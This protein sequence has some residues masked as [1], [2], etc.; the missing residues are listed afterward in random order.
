MK[1]LLTGASS[2]I[3][4]FLL[5][6]LVEEGH[7]CICVSRKM[8]DNHAGIQWVIADMIE[9]MPHIWQNNDAL[10]WVHLGFLP[11]VISHLKAASKAGVR[12]FIAFSSTSVFTK[13][14]SES[15]KE[16]LTIQCLLEAEK[17][18]QSQCRTYGVAWTLFR[19]TMI[20]GCGMDQNIAFI[21]NTIA[22]F[23]IFPIAGKAK[24]LRQPV[25]A[26]DLAKAC[27][28][29]LGAESAHNKA[30]NLSGGEVLSYHAM[31]EYVFRSMNRT[32]KIIGVPLPIYKLAIIILKQV[33]SRH[34][35]IQTAMVDRMNM[36]MVFDH[37]DAT[38]DFD[39][40][41]RTFQP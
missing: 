16:R 9:D 7:Q 6:M 19:P 28:Q 14:K 30:Y 41:P 34:K 20:Y 24:G 17:E 32:P 27:L 1:I 21:Q 8:Y 23:G 29:V 12:H 35:F 3:G 40:N 13:E 36:D 5:P 11:L 22:R 18:V 33:S 38:R 37:A 31:V 39:Y 10:I 26:E 4:Q 15:D 2:Q 25:H